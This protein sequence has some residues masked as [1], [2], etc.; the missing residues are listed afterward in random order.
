MAPKGDAILNGREKKDDVKE[1]DFAESEGLEANGLL[2][3]VEELHDHAKVHGDGRRETE[4]ALGMV[5]VGKEG[6][7][8][9]VARGKA[10]GKSIVEL[11]GH[12][13]LEGTFEAM[14]EAKTLKLAFV[15]GNE[16][17]EVSMGKLEQRVDRTPEVSAPNH[18]GMVN[19]EG[20]GYGPRG[21]A[22][23]EYR[24]YADLAVDGGDGG[25]RRP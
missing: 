20:A 17:D 2:D 9:V 7:A 14:V 21:P 5:P 16:A 25:H 8:T 4:L 23:D 3:M 13:W 1:G 22:V 18:G 12:V 6:L 24:N 15:G 19:Q 11:P 10:N